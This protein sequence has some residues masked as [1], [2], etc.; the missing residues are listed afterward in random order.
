M[1]KIVKLGVILAIF[2]TI[3]AGMLAFV[4]LFTQPRIELNSKLALEKA[5]L[6]VLPASGKGKAISVSPRGYSGPI[7][8]LVGVDP[9]GKVS[10]VKILSQRETPGLGAGI[11]KPSFLK[12]FIG[13]SSKDPIEPKKDIDAITGATIS[14]RAVC[15]G[16]RDA[17]SLERF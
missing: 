7:E 9:K 1:G 8:M 11:V 16:V 6:E 5:K 13:K 3:S 17:L 14:S 10:G 4:Y 2:C 12:Q 15:E